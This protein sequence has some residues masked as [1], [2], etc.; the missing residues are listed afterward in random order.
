[1]RS[2][3]LSMVPISRRYTV[4]PETGRMGVL[5]S[6]GRLPPKAALVRAMRSTLPVHMLPDGITR[7]ALL[8]AAMASSGEI[9]YCRSLSG[10]SVMTMVRWLPPNG[11]GADTPGSVA[12][13]GRTRLTAKSCISPCERVALLKTNMPTATL[14]ASK[15]V[16]KGGTVPGGMKERARFTYP[17]VSAIAWLML[18]P[19]M[20]HQLHE[21][22]ALDAFTIHVVDAGDVE[23]VILVVVREVAFH[24]RGVHAAVGLRHVDGGVSDLRKDVGGHALDSEDGAQGDR[25]EGHHHGQRSA[26]RG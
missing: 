1:M 23:E 24:L 19:S 3:P 25:D 2:V 14:P 8:T 16:M 17:T 10:S 26:K 6:S 13:S 15:R 11:G 5:I 20:E 22:R 4:A 7:V 12:N 18:V 9:R 21:R